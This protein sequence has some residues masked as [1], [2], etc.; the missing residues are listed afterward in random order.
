MLE[1]L[2]PRTLLASGPR[3][4]AITPTEVINATFDHVDV[5][6][7]EAIDPTT[8]TTDDVSLTGPPDVGAVTVTG[9]TQL[10]ATDYRVSFAALNERGTYQVAIGPNIADP[11]GNLMD[12][13]QNG[14]NGEPADKFVSSLNYVVA[15]T[16]FTTNTVI[17]RGRHDLRR[18]GHRDPGSDRHD[19][20]PAFLRFR[21]AHRRGRA[22][23]LRRT[24]RLR[25]T[26]ST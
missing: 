25:R 13:N 2:E 18:P 11:Q 3:I 6:F 21:P 14:I 8:F 9:V 23:P 17:Q 26:R 7:N 16:V 22:D 4:T 12:Q 10:D 24:P 19:R 5:T 1:R 15:S 20:R